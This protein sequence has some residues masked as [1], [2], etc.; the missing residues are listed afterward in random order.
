MPKIMI[1]GVG[2][3]G[4]TSLYAPLY[5]ITQSQKTDWTYFYEPYLWDFDGEGNYQEIRKRFTT[6]SALS[7]EGIYYHRST[8]LFLRK[9]NAMNS[10][11]VDK[12]FNAND[13]NVLAKFIRASGR[14]EAYLEHAPDIKVV[15]VCRNPIG[16]INSAL[17][18]FSFF[19]DEFHASDKPRFVREV[20]DNFDVGLDPTKTR[21]EVQW[22]VHWWRFM[23]KAA[24]HAKERHPERVILISQEQMR[25][26]FD[27]C[28]S[29]LCKYFNLDYSIRDEHNQ[30]N[31][32]VG[33]ITERINLNRQQFRTLLPEYEEY[34]TVMFPKFEKVVQFDIEKERE[35]L[36]DWFNNARHEAKPFSMAVNPDLSPL[37][38]RRMLYD[39][40]RE[41]E[42]LNSLRHSSLMHRAHL[43]LKKLRK[44]RR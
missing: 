28:M 1:S 32:I 12:I 6:T 8:P 41:L 7:A 31:R 18:F 4:T 15:H 11:F 35:T 21:D 34:W 44:S 26:D 16:T 14:L 42:K 19:G 33:P 9:N 38:I 39:T 3:S 43:K 20:L 10:Q 2:R 30:E 24:L 27:A 5:N 17:G 36:F 23:N 13:S 37:T 40:T 22:S 25:N 29:H